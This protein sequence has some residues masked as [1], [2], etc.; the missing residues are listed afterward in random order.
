M[1]RIA[2]GLAE[3]MA[4]SV[5]CSQ[6]TYAARGKRAP[7]HETRR[8][9]E[10]WRCTGTTLDKNKLLFRV[11]NLTTITLSIFVA[12]LGRL[13]RGDVVVA[14]TN[15]PTLP[16]AILVACRL[17]G[18]RCVLLVHDVYPDVL[19]AS[20]LLG[21]RNVAISATRALQRGLFRS[22]DR[23]IVLGRDMETLVARQMGARSD[24][25]LRIPNWADLAEIRPVSRLGNPMLANLG[26]SEKFVVQYSGNMG[27]T[28]ALECLVDAAELLQETNPA[29]HFLFIGSGA[30]RKWLEQSVHDRGLRNV[31]ILP[32]QP[33]ESLEISLNACDVA[34]LSFV[35]GMA[36]VSV[37]SRMYNIMAAGRPILAAADPESELAQL[38]REERIGWIVPPDVPERIAAAVVDAQRDVDA[39]RVM[40][41]RARE[42]A[43]AKY[44]YEFVISAYRGLLS[45]M[46]ET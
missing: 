17:R 39:L 29:V 44:S 38:V 42:A 23:I 15:P 20:G 34:V 9:V 33:R 43:E 16:F 37:P 40:G 24:R 30:K 6:P 32:Y 36:G 8:G 18:A 3:T 25:L 21:K 19:V 10:I 22:V 1:T 35:P 7:R 4:V 45:P 2:E 31:T 41:A 12:A 26:L 28:H 27:R 5:L 13:R 11:M 46:L 14:V